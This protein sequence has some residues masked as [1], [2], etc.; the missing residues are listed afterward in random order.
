MQYIDAILVFLTGYSLIRWLELSPN[1]GAQLK[2][3]LLSYAMFLGLLLAL[4][5]AVLV[6][7]NLPAIVH[8]IGTG[9]IDPVW[10]AVGLTA[11]WVARILLLEGRESLRKRRSLRL[12]R[13]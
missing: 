2:E 6:L 10:Y 9:R 3:M 8:A 12:G 1:P 11:L 7:W 5:A 13:A 4:A